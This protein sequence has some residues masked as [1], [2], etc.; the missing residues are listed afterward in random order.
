[1][2][3]QR[4][5]SAETLDG[6]CEADPAAIR[7]RRDLQ[8]VHRVMGTRSIVC[9]ALN[10][11]A[12]P[13]GPQRLRMLELGAGDGTLMLGVARALGPGWSNVELTLLD[14]QALVRSETIAAYRELGWAVHVKVMDVVDWTRNPFPEQPDGEPGAWDVIVAN[15]FVHH[16]QGPTLSGILQAVAASCDAFLACEPH[17]SRFALAGSRLIGALGA[18][19]VTR[20]DAVLSVHAGFRDTE[21]TQFWPLSG[22]EWQLDEYSAGL[23]SHCLFAR[24]LRRPNG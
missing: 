17:R 12:A 1:M 24:R 10:R 6:L 16:F 15:L 3:L 22:R 20:N 21:I 19:A 8:R 18:N 4:T 11:I 7:S 2:T 14:R 9:R 5:V 23:F 13:A